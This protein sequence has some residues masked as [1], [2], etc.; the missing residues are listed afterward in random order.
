M[1]AFNLNNIF[2][3][4]EITD[5]ST[6]SSILI[7]IVDDMEGDVI[8]VTTVLGGAL[9]TADATVTVSKN[10]TSMGTITV[11][12]TSSAAGDIDNLV[13]TSNNS[14]VAGDYLKIATDGGSTG[15]QTLGFVVTIRR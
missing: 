1:S 11:A 2:V 12:Y 13:P 5:V 7:P 14:L 10:T 8:D 6:A 15:T 3:T 9:T 4:G